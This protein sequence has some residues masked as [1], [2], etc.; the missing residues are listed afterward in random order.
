MISPVAR[1]ALVVS[2]IYILRISKKARATILHA[3]APFL[4]DPARFNDGLRPGAGKADGIEGSTGQRFES[5]Q[6]IS[7]CSKNRLSVFW[8]NCLGGWARPR[9]GRGSGCL[10][11]DFLP[12]S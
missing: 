6:P 10:E 1:A 4:A 9:P 3:A 5:F 8:P 11:F 7:H 2:S 12:I